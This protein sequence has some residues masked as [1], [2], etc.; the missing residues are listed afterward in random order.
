MKKYIK[1]KK[2]L[3][4]KI[5]TEYSV[6]TELLH[7]LWDLGYDRG[8]EVGEISFID[9]KNT[10]LKKELVS[11]ELIRSN[12]MDQLDDSEK[13]IKYYQREIENLKRTILY[14]IGGEKL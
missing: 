14:K 1:D 3:M 5:E 8:I 9:T 13:E 2:E 10:K 7:E 6:D 11:S 12:L 4:N